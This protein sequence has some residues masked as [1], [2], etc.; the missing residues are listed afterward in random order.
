MGV[1]TLELKVIPEVWVSED[2]ACT[3]SKNVLVILLQYLAYL[4]FSQ[5]GI[6]A[7]NCRGVVK[8]G[9]QENWQFWVKNEAGV[10]SAFD[11]IVLSQPS[12][13]KI[14]SFYLCGHCFHGF[15]QLG[16]HLL[17]IK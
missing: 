1:L 3:N 8:Q 15:S 2:V 17:R 7:E 4:E 10:T 9:Y 11:V 16:L 12:P 13:T 14:D 5:I 6:T